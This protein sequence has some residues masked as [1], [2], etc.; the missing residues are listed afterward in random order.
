MADN[1]KILIV[2]DREENLFALEILLRE[3]GAEIVRAG[4]G[5]EA[6]IASLY[7]DFSLAILDVQMPEMD[8]YELAR[9]FREEEKTRDMPIIFLSAVYS[10]EYHVF[11]GY[12]SGAV[13]FITKPYNPEIFLCKVNIFLHREKLLQEHKRS[14]EELSRHREHLERLVRER[15]IELEERAARLQEEINERRRAEE[16]NQLLASI[17]ESSDDAIVGKTL[18]GVISRDRKSV[19]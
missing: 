19:V 12:E 9:Y 2:D 13:D 18:D 15:T 10:D 14:E 3:T 11:K 5:N 7:H 6:L 17:V 16:I 4:N 1:Q 8:G